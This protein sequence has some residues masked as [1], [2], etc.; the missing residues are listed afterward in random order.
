MIAAL[1]RLAK[2]HWPALSIRAI[3]LATFVFVAALPGVG[4]V[5]LRVYENTLVQQTEAE[6]TAQGAVLAA[7][8]RAAWGAPAAPRDDPV[9]D[10]PRIDLRADPVLP[11]APAPVRTR[12]A[13]PRAARVGAQLAPIVRDAAAMTLASTR[14][15]D[16]A[17]VVVAGRGD[18]GLSYAGLVEVRRAAS[19]RPATVLRTRFDDPYNLH[20]PLE[21]LSRAVNIRVHHVQPVTAD[22]AVIGMVMAWRSPR[23]LFVGIA[24]DG[25][26]IAIGI[27]LIFATLMVLAGLLSRGIARPIRA[28]TRASDAV[29]RGQVSIP[30]SPATAAIEIRELYSNFAVMA[31]RIDA[32]NR[33][34]RDFATAVSHE[35]KTPL[36]GIRGALELLA[37][38]D[39]GED[40]RRRFLANA[41]ADTERL[42]RLVQRLLDLARADMADA[43]DAHCDPAAVARQAGVPGLTVTVTGE[44][45]RAGIAAE[46]LATVLAVL[47]DNSRQ[48]GAG[49]V[50]VGIVPLGDRITLTW[51]DDGPGV[52][53]GDRD[54]IFLPFFTDRREQG[55]TGIGLAIARSLLS[56][57][58]GTIGLTP[59]ATGA[60]FAIDLPVA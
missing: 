30:E 39:M 10:P 25:G 14:I 38:H 59:S 53:P 27:V 35:F 24:Q 33:Y 22:G 47:A 46:A 1:K 3:L 51:H 55:G 29:A 57:S 40:D 4:A 52:P 41:T 54:R 36:T 6:L 60:A 21:W 48:A 15:L 7:A 42:S 12:P 31:E 23:G 13:D 8:Y 9:A 37:E 18:V 43:S 44:A 58:G 56:A 16:A 45:P 26:K 32:R 5:F 20:S 50:A 49:S 11:A 19:G 17:G 34:L 2:R 28:L